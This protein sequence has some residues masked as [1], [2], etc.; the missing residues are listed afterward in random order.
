MIIFGN[1]I[2]TFAEEKN[3][4]YSHNFAIAAEEAYEYP[5]TVGTD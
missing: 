2:T 5:L 3:V 1:V 4:N